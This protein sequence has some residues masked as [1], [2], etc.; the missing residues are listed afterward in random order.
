MKTYEIVNFVSDI[1]F[2]ICVVMSII[3]LNLIVKELRED[4]ACDISTQLHLCHELRK[5]IERLENEFKE[6]FSKNKKGN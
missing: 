1:V 6:K 4:R 3:Y 5:K 2:K